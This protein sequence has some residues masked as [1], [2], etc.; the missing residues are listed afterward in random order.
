MRSRTQFRLLC[1]LCVQPIVTCL[2]TYC[3]DKDFEQVDLD[4][5]VLKYREANSVT[6]F[7]RVN[8]F[9]IMARVY[10]YSSIQGQRSG[11]KIPGCQGR[12]TRDFSKASAG[13]SYSI[14]GNKREER[15]LEPL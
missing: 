14:D 6:V 3:D 12:L 11:V 13:S 9:C 8:D 15:V 4:N 10:S 1:G 5:D 2:H 7:P